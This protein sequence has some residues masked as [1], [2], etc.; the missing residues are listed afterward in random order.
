MTR[1]ELFTRWMRELVAPQPDPPPDPRRLPGFLRPP[2]AAEETEFVSICES[3]HKCADACPHDVILPLGPAYGAAEGTPAILPRGDPC[4]LCDDLPCAAACPSGALKPV[5]IH[6]VR[7]GIARLDPARCWAVMKQPCDYCVKECP[8][9]E[10]A[11]RWSD[12]RPEVIE[13]GC[14]GC[15]MCVHICPAIPSALEIV[16]PHP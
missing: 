1:R 7:M 2:G 6:Q 11:L 12:D 15:G 9:G 14:V 16:P 8:L 3:S 5:P 10:I 13:E 4:R